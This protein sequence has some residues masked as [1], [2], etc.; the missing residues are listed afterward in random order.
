MSYFKDGAVPMVPWSLHLNFNKEHKSFLLRPEHFSPDGENVTKVLIDEIESIDPKWQVP[1]GEP[2]FIEVAT[3]K[4]LKIRRKIDYS[5]L[6][7]EIDNWGEPR[8]PT[9]FSIMDKVFEKG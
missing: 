1:G 9:F 4:Q 8:E 7:N 5:N 3:K 2:V 6:Q